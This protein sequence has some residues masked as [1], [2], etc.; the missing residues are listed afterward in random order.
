M[1]VPIAEYV[2][3]N[4]RDCLISSSVPEIC[5]SESCIVGIDEAGRGP[6]LGPMV[7]GIAYCPISK[8]EDLVRLGVDDSK[9]LTDGKRKEILEKIQGDEEYSGGWAVHIL[10]PSVISE[11]MFRRTKYNLNTMSHDTAI[12]LI[13]SILDAGVRVSK[14]FVDTVGP[15]DKYEAKLSN[16]FPN[17]EI[18]V[19][20]KADS[21]YPIVSAAS[22][23]AKVTRDEALRQWEFGP[24]P[25]RGKIG[26]GY[27][28]DAVTKSFLL[29]N[30]H[31]LF[32]FPNVVRFSWK[33]A[34][35]ICDERGIPMH[36]EEV[37]PQEEELKDP[38]VKSYFTFHSRKAKSASS[39]ERDHPYFRERGLTSTTI[40]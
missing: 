9:A 39:S 21:L 20:K 37:E 11:N 31:P 7:Y 19:S 16:L 25:V 23:V 28:G 12:G 10:S 29:N 27:P 24:I 14:V 32:G 40:F 1:V 26:S 30:M 22:I 15:P 3:D 17:L 8:E 5:K 38:S 36:F 13:R 2:S 6:V 4:D 18:K 35:K 34:E 33:T